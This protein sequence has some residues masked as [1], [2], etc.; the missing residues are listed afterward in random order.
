DQ[1]AS[2]AGQSTPACTTQQHGNGT[3]RTQLSAITPSGHVQLGNYLGA[4]RRWAAEQRPSSRPAAQAEAAQAE[5]AQAEAAQQDAELYFVSDLHAMTTP[6]RPERLRSL[7]QEQ[8]AVLLA[9]G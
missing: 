9:A 4:V 2:V 5:A 3:P 6:H 7:A 8:L 1:P